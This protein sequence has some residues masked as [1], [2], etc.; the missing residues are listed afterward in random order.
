MKLGDCMGLLVSA[1][2]A[3]MSVTVFGV[4]GRNR[5]KQVTPYLALFIISKGWSIHD[6]TY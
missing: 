6:V 2:I 5:Q 1:L 4:L 3:L